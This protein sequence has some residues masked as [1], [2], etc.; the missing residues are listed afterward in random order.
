M[1]CTNVARAIRWYQEKQKL[2]SHLVVPN[3]TQHRDNKYLFICISKS[4]KKKKRKKEIDHVWPIWYIMDRVGCK[5]GPSLLLAELNRHLY[6]S[7]AL[8]EKQNDFL[9]NATHF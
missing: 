8:S 3:V 5:I 4:K 6:A 2:V 9:L 1:H 7:E